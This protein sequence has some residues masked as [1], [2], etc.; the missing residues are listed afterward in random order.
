MKKIFCLLLA[1]CLMLAL[2]ACGGDSGSTTTAPEG[3][4][5]IQGNTEP[6]YVFTYNGTD[7][8]M[9]ASAEEIL[10]ALG[11]AK[12][13]TE[14]ASCAFEG[15]DKTYYYGSFYLQT[16]PLEG[17]DYIYSLWLMDDSVQTPEGIFIG[18][19]KAQVEAAYGAD[20]FNGD[21]AYILA[22][23]A[24]RLTIILESGLVS[25]IQYDAI[26]G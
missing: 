18:A 24:S 10:T 13:C 7:V 1:L 14:E 21:N 6:G 17:K 16:Y 19:T 11:E 12:S 26:V 15:L 20:S 5:N 9:N 23:G 3:D 8:V 4:S 22:K 2:A 25:S